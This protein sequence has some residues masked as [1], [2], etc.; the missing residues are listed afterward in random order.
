MNERVGQGGSAAA[1][2]AAQSSRFGRLRDAIA[3][4]NW[5]SVAIE[6]LIVTVG[7]LLAFQIDQW[8]DQRKQAGEERQ[9][10]ERLYRENL[11]SAAELRQ[12]L[13]V[14]EDTV[15]EVGSAIRARG[16]SAIVA[17]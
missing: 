17:T 9:F 12:V 16:Q 2:V 11:S 10:L 13:E 14:H 6:I 8:G 3:D 1:N 15:R 7:I 4:H 5:F